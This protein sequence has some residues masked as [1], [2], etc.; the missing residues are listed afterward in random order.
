MKVVFHDFF[1]HVYS[2]DPAAEAGRMEAAISELPDDVRMVSAEPATEAD[3]LL[4]LLNLQA[5]GGGCRPRPRFGISCAPW[6]A[7]RRRR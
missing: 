7:G 1:H 5:R 6:R 2:S 3:L 4:A